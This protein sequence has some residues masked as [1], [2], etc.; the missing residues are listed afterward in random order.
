M[1]DTSGRGP[2]TP[3]HAV[4]REHLRAL[5]AG[6]AP[7]TPAPSERLLVQEF[8]MARTTVRQAIDAL[9]A[10][11]LLERLP[12]KGTY[13]ARP[14]P[15]PSRLTSFTE[16]MAR[17]GLAV[18]SRT[19]EAELGRASTGVARA[20]ELA[21]GAPVIRWRRLRRAD[22]QPMC[23]EEAYLDEALLPG[24]LEAP[25]PASLYAELARRD[26]RP[27]WAEDSIRADLASAPEAEL[28]EVPPGVAVLRRARRALCDGRPVSVSR[29]TYRADRYT[30]WVQFVGS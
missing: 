23:V 24:F 9:V 28:L 29:S 3:K 22:G 12:S 26:L 10:E 20:L 30:A 6:A 7:G 17:R 2:T 16:D 1:S 4:V 13:V 15:E 25:L 11:G 27:T 5:L 14:Q 19:L 21:Q 8:G 18:E